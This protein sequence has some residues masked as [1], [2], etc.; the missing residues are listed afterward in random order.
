MVSVQ[1]ALIAEEL[2][3]EFG[4][5]ETDFGVPSAA[6]WNTAMADEAVPFMATD[7]G[8]AAETMRGV[9]GGL[10]KVMGLQG[11]GGST[12]VADSYDKLRHAGAVTRET[13]KLAA[14]QKSGVPV[15]QLQEI[16]EVNSPSVAD[17]F[18]A[19]MKEGK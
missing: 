8:T 15:E 18:V 4:Q 17:L 11:T 19:K 10:L 9:A 12:T 5:F 14:S 16:G 3:V 13:L 7:T 2:D 1:A 6:Y